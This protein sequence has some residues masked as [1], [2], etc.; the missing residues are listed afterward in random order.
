[1]DWL[2]RAT[3]YTRHSPWFVRYLASAGL[4]LVCFGLFRL[5]D[6]TDYIFTFLFPAILLSAALFD[7]GA[8]FLATILAALVADFDFMAPRGAFIPTDMRD[9]AALLIF[10]I[11]GT[12]AAGVIESLHILAHGLRKRS[13]QLQ[14]ALEKS[15]ELAKQ[16]DLLYAEMNHRIRNQLQI[17]ASLLS[18]QARNTRLPAEAALL[19]AA[20]R[21]MTMARLHQALETSDRTAT[22]QLSAFLGELCRNLQL[23][24]AGHRQIAVRCQVDVPSVSHKIASMLG[25]LISEL[26]TNAFKHAFSDRDAGDILVSLSESGGDWVLRVSDDG[27]GMPEGVQSGT[28]RN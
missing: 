13:A 2:F 21:V 4:V 9:A 5:L 8:G 17:M 18:Y 20:D 12:T 15:E 14:A 7:R 3:E 25:L 10:L 24:M 27:I 26:I 22:V 16:N 23:S 28:V 11:S 6:I 19:A 1:M